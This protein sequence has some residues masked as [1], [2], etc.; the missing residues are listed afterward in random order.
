MRFLLHELLLCLV[1]KQDTFILPTEKVYW[2]T[3]STQSKKDVVNAIVCDL[4][5]LA[6]IQNKLVETFPTTRIWHS[7]KMVI[8]IVDLNKQSQIMTRK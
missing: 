2:E 5:I 4:P 3:Y 8:D 7:K 6:F 1:N